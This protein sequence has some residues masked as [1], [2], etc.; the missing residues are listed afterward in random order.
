MDGLRT[1]KIACS[2]LVIK[3][4]MIVCLFSHDFLETMFFFSIIYHMLNPIR[5]FEI[6]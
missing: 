2:N 5:H 6:K 1:L 4:S 3:K